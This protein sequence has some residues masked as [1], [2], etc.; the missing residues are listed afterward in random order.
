MLC[1]L[2]YG[3]IT[4]LR[5]TT[6]R[7]EENICSEFSV[8]FHVMPLVHPTKTKGDLA[9]AHA[10]TDLMEQGYLVLW[11]A[12][13]HAPFDVVAYRDGKFIRVQVK[14]RSLNARGV[15]DIELG[16]V[17]SDRHGMHRRPMDKSEVDIVCVYCP[18]T[19]ACY[20][21]RPH[22]HGNRVMLR[23]VAAKN[24]QAKG[25]HLAEDF[26][27]VPEDEPEPPVRLP[28]G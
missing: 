16:S 28:L 17:W 4:S 20:Y 10:Y 25:V 23:V 22:G 15:L 6:D 1:P 24:N 21:F 26:R 12:T 18:A 5:L 3:G 8:Y 27:R 11:P 19:R 7:H 9:V 14:Y 13:E 2:S